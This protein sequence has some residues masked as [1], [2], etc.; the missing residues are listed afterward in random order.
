VIAVVVVHD[1][2]E[3]RV[4]LQ[5]ILRI[6]ISPE[7]A[8]VLAGP[9]VGFAHELRQPGD[10]AVGEEVIGERPLAQRRRRGAVRPVDRAASSGAEVD[11]L[12]HA[13][14][15]C[16]VAALARDVEGLEES[17]ALRRSE[18]VGFA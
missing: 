2:I 9:L 7:Q 15:E 10:F 8:T 11:P 12:E 1:S 5:E 17:L 14:E 4:D 13:G 3:L 6:A 18:D 16:R